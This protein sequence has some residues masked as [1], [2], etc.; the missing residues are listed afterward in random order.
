[1]RNDFTILALFEYST[2]AQVIK[3]KLDSEG[4]QTM[5]MDEKTVDSDPLISQAIGGVKLLIH[6]TD[7]EKATIIYNDI[8]SYQKDERGNDIHCPKCNSTK[9][10]VADLQRKNIFFMLFPFFESRKLICN[11]CKTVFK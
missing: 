8:R 7:L 3:A 9:T 11:D 10:L 4:I 6:N 1:M 5:L 2:E